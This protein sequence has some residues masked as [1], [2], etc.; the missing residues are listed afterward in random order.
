LCV[1]RL[2]ARIR[3]LDLSNNGIGVEGAQILADT[4]LLP[5]TPVPESLLL[6]KCVL[7][8]VCFLACLPFSSFFPSI[9]PSIH[10]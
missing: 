10:P 7:V 3:I 4:W 8:C 9:H 2:F 6:A 1:C 5:A